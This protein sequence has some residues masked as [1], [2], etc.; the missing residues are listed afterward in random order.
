MMVKEKSL[1]EYE[2][3]LKLETNSSVNIAY[4]TAKLYKILKSIDKKAN[5][6]VSYRPEE[7]NY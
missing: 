1:K 2:F 4:L 5:V 6:D 7:I 3:T